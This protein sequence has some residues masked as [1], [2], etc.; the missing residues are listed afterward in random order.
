MRRYPADPQPG[1]SLLLGDRVVNH[2]DV[3]VIGAGIVGAACAWQLAK[4][5]QK[6]ILLDDRQPGA[7][8]AGMGHLVCMDD[9]PAELALSA[10]SLACW[11]TLTP[12]MP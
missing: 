12:R 11:R 1:R 6:V 3:I 4:R 7:T 9:D 10:W 2:G 8:A 5:G